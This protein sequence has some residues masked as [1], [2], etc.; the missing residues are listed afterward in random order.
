[1][2]ITVATAAAINYVAKSPSAI[3]GNKNTPV[4]VSPAKGFG[5][6]TSKPAFEHRTS[7]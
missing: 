1:M 3:D 2:G 4:R 6:H 5:F 7:F